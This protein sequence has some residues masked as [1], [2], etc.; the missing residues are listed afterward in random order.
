MGYNTKIATDRLN[1]VEWNINF[2]LV[3]VLR[4][5]FLFGYKYV[6]MIRISLTTIVVH[7]RDRPEVYE[8]PQIECT[9]TCLV[10]MLKS[11]HKSYKLIKPLR[12]SLTIIN[13]QPSNI[14]LIG[15]RRHGFWH[16]ALTT[17]FSI[18]FI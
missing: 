17:H 15:N 14:K 7:N 18:L 11:G 8:N 10:G 3:Q 12:Y 5:P 6:L 2:T 16:M 4:I 13:I 1:W 9:I